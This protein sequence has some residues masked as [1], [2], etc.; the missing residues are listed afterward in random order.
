MT[1]E[2]KQQLLEMG[3]DIAAAKASPWEPTCIANAFATPGPNAIALTMQG[4]ID[5]DHIRSPILNGEL[6]KNIEE[7]KAAALLAFDLLFEDMPIEDVMNVGR[8]MCRACVDAFALGLKMVDSDEPATGD[9]PSDGFGN[10]LPVW[11]CLITQC[12]LSL[13]DA[14]TIRVDQAHALVATMRRNAGW[15]VAGTPYALRGIEEEAQ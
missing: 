15:K 11:A 1:A 3:G 10:W 14:R 9:E 12:G 7:L 6:P 8:A 2:E 5:L 13:D 4:W